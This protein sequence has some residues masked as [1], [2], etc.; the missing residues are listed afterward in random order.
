MLFV[1]IDML[2][3]LKHIMFDFIIDDNYGMMLKH[4]ASSHIFNQS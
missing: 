1:E 4:M 2:F 3:V